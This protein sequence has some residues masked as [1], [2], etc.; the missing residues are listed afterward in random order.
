MGSGTITM[1]TF[2]HNTSQRERYSQSRA[3]VGLPHFSVPPGD[4]TMR[5]RRRDEHVR[6]L[7]GID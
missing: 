2:D 4:E 7:P 3:Y 6:P 1:T 5:L